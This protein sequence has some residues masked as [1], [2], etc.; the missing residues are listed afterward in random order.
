MVIAPS[1]I[2]TMANGLFTRNQYSPWLDLPWLYDWFFGGKYN[3]GKYHLPPTTWSRVNT[4]MVNG[5]GKDG[6]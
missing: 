3:H 6:W 2:F 4:T 1:T 5:R